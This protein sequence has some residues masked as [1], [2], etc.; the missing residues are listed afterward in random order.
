MTFD[1]QHHS[2]CNCI[3]MKLSNFEVIKSIGQGGFGNVFIARSKRD[4][5]GIAE[6]QVVCIKV[7]NKKHEFSIKREI[8]VS[9]FVNKFFCYYSFIKTW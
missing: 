2:L 4:F 9:V 3:T 6:N 1:S 5:D 7:I 8:E